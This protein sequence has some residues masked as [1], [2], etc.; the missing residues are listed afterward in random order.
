MKTQITGGQPK[1]RDLP[2]DIGND[3]SQ[4]MFTRFFCFAKQSFGLLP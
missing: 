4:F 3:R 2:L 1:L